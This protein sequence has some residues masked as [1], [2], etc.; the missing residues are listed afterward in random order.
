MITDVPNLKSDQSLFIIDDVSNG[1]PFPPTKMVAPISK[2]IHGDLLVE[3]RR[4]VVV[5]S[6]FAPELV[7][8]LTSL[9]VTV[10][11]LQAA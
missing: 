8:L 2:R 9:T 3:M 5:A 10:D 6:E 11:E 4:L 1:I 7:K